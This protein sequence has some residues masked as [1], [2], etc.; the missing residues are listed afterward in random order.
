MHFSRY[1]RSANLDRQKHSRVLQ[2]ACTSLMENLTRHATCGFNRCLLTLFSDRSDLTRRRSALYADEIRHYMDFVTWFPEKRRRTSSQPP[3]GQE[4]MSRDSP[5]RD[6]TIRMTR[7]VMS[8]DITPPRS[9]RPQPN[10][11][12]IPSIG[13][14][15]TPDRTKYSILKSHATFD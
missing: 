2:C 8:R 11:D 10:S 9:G 4:V 1:V 5:H 3:P 6:R 14:I 13:K 15:H 12:S 7:E